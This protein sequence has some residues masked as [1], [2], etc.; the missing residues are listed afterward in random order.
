MEW[1]ANTIF[2]RFAHIFKRVYQQITETKGGLNLTVNALR[3]SV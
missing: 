3:V 2:L 1:K